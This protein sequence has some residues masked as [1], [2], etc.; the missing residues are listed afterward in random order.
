MKMSL[1]STINMQQGVPVAAWPPQ[2]LQQLQ[3]LQQQPMPQQQ[4]VVRE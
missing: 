4:Q 1:M 3:Q 2:Q